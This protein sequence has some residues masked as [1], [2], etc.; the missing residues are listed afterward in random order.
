MVA[1]LDIVPLVC[2]DLLSFSCFCDPFWV[3]R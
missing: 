2:E 3:I 1:I